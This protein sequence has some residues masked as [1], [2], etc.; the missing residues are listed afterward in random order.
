MFFVRQTPLI[1]EPHLNPSSSPGLYRRL[2]SHFSRVPQVLA[3]SQGFITFQKALRLFG[4][5]FLGG[6]FAWDTLG[7]ARLTLPLGR[8]I[9]GGARRP[10]ICQGEA[11]ITL[12]LAV[13][14][15][16]KSPCPTSISLLRTLSVVKR[17]L[18]FQNL[19]FGS[20]PYSTSETCVDHYH[21]PPH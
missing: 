12:L 21:N 14:G 11:T 20:D 19:T 3:V 4:S 7:D 1:S 9:D 5:W 2:S 6:Y 15:G 10:S 8:Y 16:V 13:A 17:I 18:Q